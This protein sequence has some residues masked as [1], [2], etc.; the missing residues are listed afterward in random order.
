[1]AAYSGT[2]TIVRSWS[3]KQPGYFAVK[4][5]IQVVLASQGSSANP[6]TAASLNLS[7]IDDCSSFVKSDDS[8]AYAGTP[9][10]D[11]SMLHPIISNAPADLTGTFQVTVTGQPGPTKVT[12]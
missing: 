1:M 11:G 5:T 2:P 8:A 10:Y 7:R 3:V 12:P 9:S 4:R 6:I